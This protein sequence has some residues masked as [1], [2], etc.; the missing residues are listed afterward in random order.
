MASRDEI[1]EQSKMRHAVE[2]VEREWG[3]RGAG[4]ERG[5]SCSGDQASA[6]A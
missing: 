2:M 1:G 5:H 3:H 4:N 6:L